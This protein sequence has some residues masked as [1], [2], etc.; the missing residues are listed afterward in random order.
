MLPD[1]DS[2]DQE[3]MCEQIVLYLPEGNLDLGSYRLN[4]EANADSTETFRVSKCNTS[5]IAGANA[6]KDLVDSCVEDIINN[7]GD[8]RS[9]TNNEFVKL[10]GHGLLSWFQT[11]VDERISSVEKISS[12]SNTH[13]TVNPACLL[14]I[15]TPPFKPFGEILFRLALKFPNARVLEV[16]NQP[17]VQIKISMDSRVEENKEENLTKQELLGWFSD[18]DTSV[19]VSNVAGVTLDRKDSKGKDILVSVD[20]TLLD[21]RY[22][23]LGVKCPIL[24]NVLR[25]VAHL[26]PRL[27]LE[28]VYDF[29]S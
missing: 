3:R 16:S 9:R 6:E 7:R 17:E 8:P 20:Y 1:Y 22:I 14:V 23:G 28:Q 26:H 19:C 4:C 24:L 11:N 15:Q 12:P 21:K 25:R 18:L 5:A 27:R 29:W 10:N 2:S 13:S